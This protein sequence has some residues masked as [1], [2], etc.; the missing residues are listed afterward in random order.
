MRYI[1]TL[2][3]YILIAINT[4]ILDKAGCDVAVNATSTICICATYLMGVL[5]AVFKEYKGE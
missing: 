2:I 1:F 5:W 3:A 4:V